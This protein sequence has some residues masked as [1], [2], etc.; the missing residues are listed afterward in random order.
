[1]T[2]QAFLEHGVQEHFLQWS[3]PFQ[4][5]PFDSSPHSPTHLL[6]GHLSDT[7][8]MRFDMSCASVHKYFDCFNVLLDGPPAA[9]AHGYVHVSIFAL[10]PRR[11]WARLV[12][13][14]H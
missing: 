13:A 11:L 14:R 12:R 4:W 9:N 8:E 3:K 2:I 6:D 1:M 10:T 7:F 5:P